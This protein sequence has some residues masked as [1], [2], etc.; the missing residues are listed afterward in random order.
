MQFGT[1]DVLFNLLALVFWFRVWNQK[2][3]EACFNPYLAP[4]D[5][6]SEVVIGFLAPVVPGLTKRLIALFVVV[7]VLLFRGLVAPNKVAW[8]LSMG[9]DRQVD[10][11]SLAACIE[12]SVLS[13]A[14]F[15]FRLWGIAIIFT[16]TN[17]RR[18]TEHPVVMLSFLSRPFSDLRIEWRPVFLLAYG[19]GLVLLLDRAGSP[20]ALSHGF[21]VQAYLNWGNEADVV[22]A[23]KVVVLSMVAWVQLLPLL[24]TLM[25]MLIIGSLISSFTSARGMYMVCRDWINLFLGPLRNHPIRL[26]MF[27]LSPIIFFI[28]IGV[29]HTVLMAVLLASL[30]ALG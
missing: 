16:I 13:F 21:S 29:V 26:G 2:E 24:Q 5:R 12:F 17:A 11:S 6:L 4:L 19:M 25:F 15:L 27:D 7:L 22:S 28:L 1:W 23:L 30:H 8:V 20:A 9:F 14:L 18:S 3:R 10:T